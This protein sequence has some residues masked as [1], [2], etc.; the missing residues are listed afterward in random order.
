MKEKQRHQN[1]VTSATPP[2]KTNKQLQAE[3]R[4]LRDRL[5]AANPETRKAMRA[6]I[7]ALTADVAALQKTLKERDELLASVKVEL[8][9][10]AKDTTEA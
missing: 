7:K 3:I 10:L 5:S 9:P 2:R 8:Q 4:M 1:K 6:H